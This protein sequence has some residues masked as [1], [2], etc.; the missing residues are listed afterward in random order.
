[1]SPL[2]ADARTE[3][4]WDFRGG[5]VPGRWDVMQTAS[6]TPE[7]T[8]IRITTAGDATLI[9]DSDVP[10]GFDTV[11]ITYRSARASE[12]KLMGNGKGMEAKWMLQIPFEIAATETSVTATI[13]SS[14]HK[15]WDPRSER[16]GLAFP[17]GTDLIIE[18][19]VFVR[20]SPIEKL[21]EAVKSFWTLDDFTGTTINFLWGPQLAFTPASRSDMLNHLPPK[22]RSGMIAIYAVFALTTIVSLVR[23]LIKTGVAKPSQRTVLITLAAL[24]LL[25]DVRMGAELIGY[26]RDDVRT[27]H[28]RPEGERTLRVRGTFNDFVESIAPLL[29]EDRAYAFLPRIERPYVHILRYMTY[30]SLPETAPAADADLRHWV[31]FERPDIGIDAEG[32]LVRGGTIISP[33]GSVTYMRESGTFLFTVNR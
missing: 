19:I 33:P 22:S 1:M 7:R 30:P 13:G 29:Q 26:A 2:S 18:R 24:W 9:R 25:L 5:T 14:A 15:E 12:A 4:A 3:H 11:E 10:F 16:V 31:V 32:R 17:A 8:G 27:Y 28:S 6:V 23:S 20:H 21:V